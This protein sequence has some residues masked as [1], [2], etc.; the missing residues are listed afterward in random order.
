MVAILM[1][2]KH[3]MLQ[4]YFSAPVN[5]GIARDWRSDRVA[6][7]TG[8]ASEQPTRSSRKYPCVRQRG[9]CHQQPFNFGERYRLAEQVALVLVATELAQQRR[10]RFGLDAFGYRLAIE[11]V[12]Q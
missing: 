4:P 6:R 11:R 1:S 10:L 5:P 3:A 9:L 2:N 8:R 12:R 7:A